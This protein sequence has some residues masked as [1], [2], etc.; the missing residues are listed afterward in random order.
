[1]DV[2]PPG[3]TEQSIIKLSQSVQ[4]C[5]RPLLQ[6]PDKLRPCHN[7]TGPRLGHPCSWPGWLAAAMR[8]RAKSH[9]GE[10]TRD[11]SS[12]IVVLKGWTSWNK[13]F[14]F[15][16][17]DTA[18]HPS[19]RPPPQHT[20]AVL[21]KNT[22]NTDTSTSTFLHCHMQPSRPH[23]TSA[24]PTPSRPSRQLVLASSI[25][26]SAITP[27]GRSNPPSFFPL[28]RPYRPPRR[29]GGE[30]RGWEKNFR[31]SVLERKINPGQWDGDSVPGCSRVSHPSH[32][33]IVSCL[34][35]TNKPQ[36]NSISS[37]PSYI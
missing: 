34:N 31:L 29:S 24:R 28:A 3:F 7:G 21:P 14:N 4:G 12:P 9:Q 19:R 23:P 1:M 25:L 15:S 13:Q 22:T 6:R 37:V 16:P 5:P 8:E 17:S 32:A 27:Q 36:L 18:H 35:H 2:C 10:K 33:G 20:M 11:D 26:S 30:D